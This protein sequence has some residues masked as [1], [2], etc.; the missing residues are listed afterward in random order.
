MN[1]LN[2]AQAFGSPGIDPR[3]THANKDGV[4]TAY[5]TS[6]RVWFTIWN[7]IITEI[8]HPTV[9]KPQIRDLQYLISDGKSFFHEEKRHLE[10]KVERMWNDGLGYRITN[11]DR[12]GRYTI[13]KEA[14]A[15]PHLSCILQHTK[16]TGDPEFIS[17][18]QLYAL[19]APHLHVRGTGNNGYAI[20]VAG[21]RILTA[22]KQGRWIA[23]AATVPFTR[24]SCGYVGQSDGWTDLADNFRMDWEFGCALDGNLALT[25]QLNLD[26]SHEFTLG[27]AFGTNLHN[28]VSTLFQSLNIP[29]EQQKQNY[30]EQWKRS[31]QDIKALEKISYDDGKLYHNSISLL[32]AHE[33]K[34]YPGALIAS[35]TIPW[36]E[37]K[38]DQDQGGY[39]LV[40][41][42]DLV[43][44]VAGLVAAGEKDTAV[45]S[46]IY[47][48]TSQQED[49]GF[50]QN[51]WVDG[52]PYWQGIQL[53]EVAFPILLA[54]LLYRENVS[55]NFNIYPMILRAAGYL[56][57]QGPVTQQERWEENSGYSP[58][59]LASN[60]AAL[61]CAAEFVRENGD[62]A[63]A[64]FIEEYADFLECHIE[65]WTV[66]T[67]GTLVAGIKQHYIRITPSV[68]N[69][70]QLNENPNQGNILIKNHPPGES[71]EFPAKEIVDGGFLQLVRYGIRKPDDPIIVNSVKVIDAILKVD[72]PVGPCWHRYN[73][74]GYGQR[75]NGE[76]FIGWGKGR[77]WPLLTGE[78]G[79]YEL[80]VGG[81]V[82]TYIKAMEGFAS[83]TCLLPEQIWDETDKPD[84]YMYLGKPTGSAMPLMWPHA[85]YIKLLR[86]TD[87][88][89]V[90]DF[91]PEVANRYLGKRNQCKSLEIWKFNRQINKVKRDYTLRIQ[92]LAA[93][94]LHWSQDNWQT[95][96]DTPATSTKLGVHFVDISVYNAQQLISFTFFWI[97]SNKWEKRDYHVVVV[98]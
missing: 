4:G 77:A 92:A 51:F 33:D 48:A 59:T 13:I 58:S 89:R 98:D 93:F 71:A 46:L 54:R 45:R 49:G 24:L 86:S 37:T 97:E 74:D 25:G 2:Q 61:I 50:A 28:A 6:S 87:D 40:W 17:Q 30:I 39:H 52:K 18:L 64:K 55:L 47:L 88:G 63:T 11:C 12:Q 82:K 73:Y 90:F 68:I 67:E 21:Y 16:I 27:L 96:K 41:T 83:D 81:D 26:D 60:I 34:T 22:E 20:E 19:C 15:D 76:P 38:N 7:G 65:D 57:R 23:L 1:I 43:S 79:H 5:S 72:T 44:S 14:I 31:R 78:R 70:S 85:E 29:F 36:G 69:N 62:I 10:S 9:D 95:I 91:I 75:K 94:Q 66:T 53:D 32:L 35:I 84:A 3:W 80:A 42:R 56:I 8:Y